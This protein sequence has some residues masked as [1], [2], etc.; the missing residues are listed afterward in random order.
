MYYFQKDAGHTINIYF[1][2][3]KS[4][5]PSVLICQRGYIDYSCSYDTLVLFGGR[6][7]VTFAPNA[8]ATHF[9]VETS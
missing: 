4:V 3:L 8:G 6:T 5:Y 2:T 7:L 1:R 9:W